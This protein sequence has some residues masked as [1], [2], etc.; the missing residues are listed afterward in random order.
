MKKFILFVFS[1][2]F[3]RCN[4]H[5]NSKKTIASDS[6]FVAAQKEIDS[7]LAAGKPTA[8]RKKQLSK[9]KKSDVAKFVI[10]AVMGRSTKG[11]SVKKNGSNYLVSYTRENDGQSFEYE[12][13]VGDSYANWSIPGGRQRNTG[14]DE[15]ISFEESGDTLVVTITYS[16]GSQSVEK[17]SK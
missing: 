4:N 7:I 14:S 17:F 3:L 1:L 16:D 11:M 6:A 15:V 12:V 13:S 5:E 9:F 8:P 2:C 10:S